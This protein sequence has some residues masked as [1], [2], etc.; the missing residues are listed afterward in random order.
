[1]QKK[2]RQIDRSLIKLLKEGWC[3]AC[4]LHNPDVHHIKTVK[5]GGDDS[6]ENCVPVC[7]RHHSMWHQMGTS[8][9]AEEFESIYEG[10]KI[11]GWEY[12][13]TRKKWQR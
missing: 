3:L 5:S 1:M 2:K 13:D 12:D 10:L 4:G 6:L 7:R 11:R 8:F 9:M